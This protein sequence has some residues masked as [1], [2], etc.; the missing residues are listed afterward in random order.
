[1][2][3][4]KDQIQEQIHEKSQTAIKTVSKPFKEWERLRNPWAGWTRVGLGL[5]SPFV[6]WIHNPLILILFVAAIFTH[7]YWFPPFK[8]K[9]PHPDT[10]T[11]LTDRFQAWLKTTSQEE[12]LL[13]F[14][15][16]VAIAVP[17]VFF[18]WTNSLFWGL[19]FLGTGTSYKVLFAQW[20]LGNDKLDEAKPKA[21]KTTQKKTTKKKTAKKAA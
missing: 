7:P 12:R 15:P 8:E 17:Y 1:M 18:M 6:L 3:L 16:G 5:I 11:K 4:D 10:M 9:Q 21:A 19:F 2:E 14:I 13:I 20:L